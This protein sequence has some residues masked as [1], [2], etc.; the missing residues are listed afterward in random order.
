MGT[1]TD[2]G[3]GH[4]DGPRGRARYMDAY[5][6]TFAALPEPI[7]TLDVRTDFG[8]VRCYRFAGS[9]TSEHPL[10]LLPGKSSGSP[11]WAD[12]MPSL[13]KIG[14]VYTLDLLGEPGLSVQDRQ[15]TSAADQAAWLAQVL[16]VLPE[17]S[18]HVLGISFGG[19]SAANL[20]LHDDGKVA[21]LTLIDAALTLARFPVR[22][23][24]HSLPATVRW[25][26]RSWRER[27]NSYM[28]GGASV[29]GLPVAEMI[30][31]GMKHFIIRLPQLKMIREEELRRI[32]VPTL[33]II[34]GSSA[35][36][37]AQAAAAAARRNIANV[38]VRVYEG[39][40]HA[41]AGEQPE[42]IARDV[43]ELIDSSE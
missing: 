15:I 26:P 8:T 6:R 39:A 7:E 12:N 34:G 41:V 28:A 25:F 1:R 43:A 30:E 22:M 42:R 4:W 40:S 36:H 16:N 5:W 35:I 23:V 14:D 17:D 21:T 10:L 3:V 20:V 37:N 27:F 9:G 24:M 18:F 38:T 31:A 29:E 2:K 19:W 32:R 11:M 33:T 13:L